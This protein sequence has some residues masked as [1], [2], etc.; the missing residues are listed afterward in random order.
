MQDDPSFPGGPSAAPE[1]ASA[2]KAD[3]EWSEF[4][5]DLD[6]LGRQLAELGT[7]GTALG[8]QFLASVQARFQEVQARAHSFK[9]AA[10]EQL[11][12]QASAAHGSFNEAR[13]RSTEAAKV[14]ARQAWERAEPL[15]QGA[16]DVG[17]GM[18]R[19][20]SELRASFG[21]A[22]QRLQNEEKEANGTVPVPTE[23]RRETP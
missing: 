8:E 2:A 16:K 11:E 18:A 14:A 7:H 3:K 4:Q 13:V 6:T 10:D 15:R 1:S 17:E 22:A 5:R 23:D 12:Q 20:W 21:K 19:A 9:L